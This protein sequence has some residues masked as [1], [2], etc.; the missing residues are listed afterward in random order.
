MSMTDPIADYL[1]RIR[2]ALQAHHR[3][4]D[5]PA[6]NMKKRISEILYKQGYIKNFIIIED[7]K[8]GIIRVFLKYDQ[9]GKP[10]IHQLQRVSKPGRRYFVDV[11]H[12]PR[13][14]NNMGIAIISTSRG[15]LTER[16]ARKDRV[17]GEVLC[18][19]W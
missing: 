6:S 10:V 1:T 4:V 14:K 19:V 7:G 15:I 3:Y 8:Q 11:D 2:N 5:I 13:V 9:N 18:Y 16:Q 17:G 12:L